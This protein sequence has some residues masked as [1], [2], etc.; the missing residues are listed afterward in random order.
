MEIPTCVEDFTIF[1]NVSIGFAAKARNFPTLRKERLP[2][3]IHLRLSETLRFL[4]T[5]PFSYIVNAAVK[6]LQDENKDDSKLDL[7][8]E[9]WEAVRPAS[10]S[11]GDPDLSRDLP[12]SEGHPTCRSDVA[13]LRCCPKSCSSWDPLGAQPRAHGWA[14]RCSPPKMHIN[15]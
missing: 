15:L 13:M 4:Q 7:A 11:G 8:K 3:K 12:G 6:S 10:G 14:R 1:V 5:W 2:K 9:H